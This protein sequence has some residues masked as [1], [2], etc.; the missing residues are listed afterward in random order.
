[1]ALL[2]IGMISGCTDSQQSV[3]TQATTAVT[4][5]TISEPVVVTEPAVRLDQAAFPDSLATFHGN[6]LWVNPTT[7]NDANT[8]TTRTT[9]LRTVDEAWRRVPAGTTLTTGYHLHLTAG[10]Y[11]VDALV[12]YWE[13]RHG[14]VAAPIIVEA[15]DGAHTVVFDGDINMYAVSYFALIGVD[16]IR[17]GDAFHCEHCDHILIRDSELSGGT[18]AHETVKVNQSQYLFIESSDIHGADDNASGTAALIELARII[19]D[20]K[21]KGIINIY[22]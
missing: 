14:T 11:P 15:A 7:G 6:D 5:P 13:D 22:Q 21:Y 12:N 2:L 18:G 17:D 9:A 3:Q 8:G 16:I 1:M 10:H 20:K 4:V 19:K